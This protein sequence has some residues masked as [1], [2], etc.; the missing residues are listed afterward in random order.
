VH[1]DVR[2][3]DGLIFLGLVAYDGT[4]WAEPPAAGTRIQAAAAKSG[5]EDWR[6]GPRY[7][8]D[9]LHRA[10]IR[11][12][13]VLYPLRY[14]PVVPQVVA[15]NITKDPYANFGGD[16]IFY[17]GT[18]STNSVTDGVKLQIRDGDEWRAAGPGEGKL[19]DVGLLGEAS[20]NLLALY[21][22]PSRYKNAFVHLKI[23][24]L[25]NAAFRVKGALPAPARNGG[26]EFPFQAVSAE[27][28]FHGKDRPLLLTNNAPRTL[29]HIIPKTYYKE[30]DWSQ[31]VSVTLDARLRHNVEGI[32]SFF[33]SLPE[34]SEIFKMSFSNES[35]ALPQSAIRLEAKKEGEGE[36]GGWFG[37]RPPYRRNKITVS[38]NKG[39]PYSSAR[40]IGDLNPICYGTME[41][42]RIVCADMKIVKPT[43][44]LP[45]DG[46]NGA[47]TTLTNALFT[48]D[49]AKTPGQCKVRCEAA[50]L[51]G[52]PVETRRMV[53]SLLKWE[54]P[55]V[56]AV[57]PGEPEPI[58]DGGV[59]NI[60]RFTY[61][62]MPSHNDAFGN[63]NITLRFKRHPQWAY[64][65]P[66]Q[67]RF[68]RIG[69]GAADQHHAALDNVTKGNPNWYVYWQQVAKAAAPL[70][71]KLAWCMTATSTETLQNTAILIILFEEV[72][73]LG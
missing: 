67:F 68:N 29:Y 70:A 5:D 56:G 23:A 57:K 2:R 64:R 35:S 37:V 60:T 43:G 50:E 30:S 62:A 41:T 3:V 52:L 19:I 51:P 28:D 8:L 59:T 12:A 17:C 54:L 55:D 65:Q 36:W 18:N 58:A 34:L 46:E 9:T 25:T 40:Q 33:H 73:P 47:T 6:S 38:E 21:T 32:P 1:M 69:T 11:P 10:G 71:R 15:N 48:F 44:T 26:Y 53:W 66:V 20:I 61:N 63:T 45:P 13:V 22:G 14:V 27:L 42:V 39:A 4:A 7:Q 31:P 24:A 72:M 49:R 16:I